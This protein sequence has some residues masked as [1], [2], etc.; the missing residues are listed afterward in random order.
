MA[1]G[2]SPVLARLSLAAL[3]TAGVLAAPQLAARPALATEAA[4]NG[5]A[6]AYE[7]DWLVT[8]KA[9]RDLIAAGAVVLDARD[10]KLKAAEPLPGASVLV[11]QDL[12]EPNLPT[13]GRLIAD[14]TV[15]TAKLQALGVSKDKP[16]VA[17]ADPVK[18]WGE[19]GRIVWTLRTLGHGKAVLVDGGL[20]ALLKD[21]P[22]PVQAAAKGDFVVQRTDRFEIKR[23]DLRASLGAP[24]L[25][26]IDAR[27]PR[28]YE[29]KTPYGETR[30]GHVPGA[31]HIWYRDFLDKDGKLLP[32]AEIEKLLASKGVSKDTSIVSYCTGG[33]RSGW[34]TTVLNDLGYTARNYA[35]SMWDWSAA[36][37][38]QYP[39]VTQN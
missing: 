14:D 19:D 12:S 4:T 10:P 2:V 30:G 11:W 8:P 36:P 15:L 16:V 26:V 39:L 32:R 1:F 37:P 33:I 5:A 9:A 13:K 23:E 27:E 29:G 25:V 31:K 24:G 18:G 35:G 28:E 20:P 21:G 17:V 38:D 34:F 7:R 6:I 3:L 22:L